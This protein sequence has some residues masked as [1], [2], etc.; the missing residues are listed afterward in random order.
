MFIKVKRSL[1]F[2]STSWNWGPENKDYNILQ[3]YYKTCCITFYYI[4]CN[5]NTF[6]NTYYI[7]QV[8][9]KMRCN[10]A[11]LTFQPFLLDENTP[12]T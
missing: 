7:L 8:Y 11:A 10:K 3:V 6:C 4:S 9:Y 5:H 2:Y 12:F 1:S